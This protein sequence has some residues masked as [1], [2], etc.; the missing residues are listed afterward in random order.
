MNILHSFAAWSTSHTSLWIPNENR[1]PNVFFNVCGVLH[2]L[3]E[4]GKMKWHM[5]GATHEFKIPRAGCARC[6]K[7]QILVLSQNSFQIMKYSKKRQMFF[8]MF[9]LYSKF[10]FKH[11]NVN[12]KSQAT[13]WRFVI[14]IFAVLNFQELCCTIRWNDLYNR[15]ISLDFFS[16][17]RMQ[18][19]FL[20]AR[21]WHWT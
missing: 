3:L 14:F 17:P 20:Q 18:F 6:D 8:V 7:R 16:F 12:F 13:E 11:G 1:K 10:T 21:P 2:I 5:I 4:L 15:S 9:L 19:G